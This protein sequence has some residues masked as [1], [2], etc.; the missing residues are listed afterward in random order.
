MNFYRIA[1]RKLKPLAEQ[2]TRCTFIEDN[3]RAAQQWAG[4]YCKAMDAEL[5][6]LKEGR[7]ALINH[8]LELI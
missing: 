5:L 2:R 8:V 3:G 6:S 1:Y 7:P 4:R